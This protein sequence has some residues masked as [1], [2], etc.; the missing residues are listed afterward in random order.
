MRSICSALLLTAALAPVTAQ[1]EWPFT[2]E[3]PRRGTEEWYEMHAGNPV[4][5]RQKHVFGKLWPVQSRPVGPRSPMVHRFHHNLYWPHPY[6]EMDAAAVQ[7]FA[8]IQ[9]INGWQDATT[10]YEYHFEPDTHELNKAGREHLYWIMSS[11]PLE[12]RTAYVQASPTDPSVDT[13]RIAQVQSYAS[14]FVGVDQVPQILLRVAR[15]HF[16]PAE[17]VNAIFDYRRENLTP[18]PVLQSAGGGGGTTGG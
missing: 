2:A 18:A 1:A 16:T 12:F 17:D 14:R 13:V 10:L 7:Q 6:R 11:V 5:Q 4:G 3:G 8:D 15:P 9:V